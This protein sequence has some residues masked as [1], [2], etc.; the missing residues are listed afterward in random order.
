MA[1]AAWEKRN[2]KAR[3]AGYRNYYDYRLH[4]YGRL[5]PVLPLES[6]TVAKRRRGT[7]GK[8][9]LKRQLAKP[10]QVGLIV[11]V[12]EAHDAEGQWTKMRFIV[13][14]TDG[15]ID[16][17]VVPLDDEEE[18]LDWWH[19]VFADAEIDFFEY[20]PAVAVAVA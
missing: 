18:D 11:E 20:E 15:K 2:A 5:P 4:D 12:P 17:Y 10:T 3:A 8:A 16:E 7:R 13:M 19:D 1:S 14:R 6:G 9:A